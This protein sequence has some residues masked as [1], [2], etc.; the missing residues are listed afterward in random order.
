MLEEQSLLEDRTQEEPRDTEPVQVVVRSEPQAYDADRSHPVPYPVRAAADWSW[1]FLAIVAAFALIGWVAWQ[2]RVV[3]FSAAIGLLLAALLAPLSGWLRRRGVHRGLA[4]A[5]TF[6]AFLILVSGSLTVVGGAVSGQFG[7]VVERAG[8]G[9]AALQEWFAGPP[10]YLTE[11]QID[12]W[13][14]RIA[15]TVSEQEQA[16]TEGAVTTAATAVEFFTGMV[17]AL[18]ALVMFL[19]DGRG[20]WAWTVRL[21]PRSA[22]LKVDGAGLQAWRTLTSFVRG[23]T[24]VALFDGIFITVLLLILQ[25]PLALPLGVLVFFGAYVPIVGAFVTGALAVLV[26]LVAN[27]LV[28]ALIVLAGIVAIQQIESNVFQPLV[29]GRMTRLHP[30]AVVLVITIGIL[31]GGILGALVAVPIAATA[32]AVFKY[33]VGSS[34]EGTLKPSSG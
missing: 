4:A 17:I 25:V 13:L 33:L 27:G 30:L 32:N 20:I 23:T 31:A 15:A 9:L 7:E 28:T 24:L 34:G 26:A 16:I 29:L 8:E 5:A 1:R 22:R 2:L 3:V 10:F 12:D 19:Y 6:L 21:F 18:F 14:D 11:Q